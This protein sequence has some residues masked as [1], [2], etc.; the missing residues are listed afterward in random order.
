MNIELAELNSLGFNSFPNRVALLVCFLGGD[1]N[2]REHR[3]LW[4]EECEH[5]GTARVVV[6]VV[7]TGELRCIV[8]T[9]AVDHRSV[10]E[11]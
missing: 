1:H 2:F 5:H 4:R 11:K 9:C 3:M 8:Q 6:G 10:V 7:G